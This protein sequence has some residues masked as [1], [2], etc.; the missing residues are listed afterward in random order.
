[1]KVKNYDNSMKSVWQDMFVQYFQKDLKV[2]LSEKILK[3]KVCS[4]ILEQ[5]SK[6]VVFISMLVLN[7]D[8]IGFAIYQID[9]PES[10]WCKRPGWG[11]IREFYIDD[12]YRRN[13]YGKHLINVIERDLLSRHVEQIYLTSDDAVSFWEK[14]GYSDEGAD[15]GG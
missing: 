3:E 12:A 1:M 10:D 6:D 7:D 8:V 11:F 4:F 13:G 14:C 5:W 15:S 9:T 2:E